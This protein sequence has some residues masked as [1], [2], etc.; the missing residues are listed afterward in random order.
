LFG[1]LLQEFAGLRTF[2][3]KLLSAN[4]PVE[5]TEMKTLLLMRHGKSSWKDAKKEEDKIRPLTKKGE[6]DVRK[7]NELLDEKDILPQV[8]LTSTA[9]RSRETANIFLNQCCEEV[10]Y[11]ALDALYMAE[12][13]NIVEVLKKV[14]NRA[15]RVIVV[16]HNPGLEGLL[17]H[18]TGQ[19]ES[20][21]TASIAY[22]ELPIAHWS[23]ISLETRA[24]K[25]EKWKPK[26][27]EA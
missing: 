15:D 14:D 2:F 23:E 10:T 7:M 9:W 24:E 22:L 4:Y 17:Q 1:V 3:V 5:E 18:L 26:E 8:I 20:L 16:G 21:S 11:I 25:W 13:V 12:P 6:K 19:V 27:K